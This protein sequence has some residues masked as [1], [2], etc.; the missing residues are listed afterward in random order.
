MQSQQGLQPSGIPINIKAKYKDSIRRF[1]GINLTLDQLFQIL[2][3]NFHASITRENSLIKYKDD[4]GDLIT[5]TNEDEWKEALRHFSSPVLYLEI[6]EKKQPSSKPSLPQQS[7]QA[8]PLV[9]HQQQQP[10]QPLG[11][12]LGLQ[13]QQP[14]RSST[15][16]QQVVRPTSPQK[17]TPT[18]QTNVL[19]QQPLPV[20]AQPQQPIQQQVAQQPPQNVEQS[21]N[22]AAVNTSVDA[23]HWSSKFI[24]D[25]SF[26]DG[27]D[28]PM[29]QPVTKTWLIRNTGQNQWPENVCLLCKDENPSYEIRYSHVPRALPGQDV[30]AS[31]TFVPKKPGLTK[32]YFRLASGKEQFGHL[33]WFELNVLPQQQVPPQVQQQP[34]FPTLPQQQVPPQQ[35]QQPLPPQSSNDL[36]IEGIH[37]VSDDEDDME[38]STFD[39]SRMQALYEKYSLQLDNL[40]QFAIL[41]DNNKDELV[42]ILEANNGDWIKAMQ[43]Y[44]M[45]SS[46][47]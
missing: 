31:V 13:Q 14:P 33:C 22:F 29:N 24:R 5:T 18:Q 1:Q 41:K 7:T 34:L 16:T 11:L 23:S 44:V 4:E 43:E 8:R 47:I 39:Q 26:P 15:P 12:P 17:Q 45:R 3:I 2:S 46:Q 42:E 32:G 9:Q 19:P 6:A 35:Q 25:I 28:V 37:D 40:K 36:S 20:Q 10:Q 27:S 38:E 21:W 30:E